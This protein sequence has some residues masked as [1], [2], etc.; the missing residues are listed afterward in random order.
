MYREWEIII[1]NFPI[2]FRFI[3]YS[4]LIINF[5]ILHNCNFWIC[6]VYPLSLLTLYQSQHLDGSDRIESDP[7]QNNCV[8]FKWLHVNDDGN[9]M[10]IHILYTQTHAHTM[11]NV[12]VCLCLSMCKC[13]CVCEYMYAMR[14]VYEL[15]CVH[16][17]WIKMLKFN[18]SS[19]PNIFLLKLVN[20]AALMVPIS[21]FL[22]RSL[23]RYPSDN[24]RTA[25]SMST[26]FNT[27]CIYSYIII[28][29]HVRR[30][31]PPLRCC[32]CRCWCYLCCVKPKY[33]F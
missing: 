7:A 23:S 14:M 28:C 22:A 10:K 27:I 2:W 26:P 11:G 30:H 29:A 24:V 20:F 6:M 33:F 16:N 31:R 1:A 5:K 25:A 13:V 8:L 12:S 3:Q 19:I 17:I 32:C 4:N 15:N 18:V 9:D 21:L